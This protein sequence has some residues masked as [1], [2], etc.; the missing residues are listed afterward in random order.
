[1]GQAGYLRR[2]ITGDGTSTNPIRPKVLE[3]QDL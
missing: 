3:R 2:M 1:L